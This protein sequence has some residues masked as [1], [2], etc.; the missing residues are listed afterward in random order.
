[1]AYKT[2]DI[3][4]N[5]IVQHDLQDKGDWCE[6]G[7][8]F[9][10]VF[11]RRYPH[12]ELIINPEKQSNIYAPDLSYRE[13]GLYADLKTQNTPFFLSGAKYGID[14]QYAVTFNEKDFLRYR[15]NYPGIDIYFWVDWQ[16]IRFVGTTEI[17][18]QPMVGVWRL[19]YADMLKAVASAS[20]H[21]Y[22]QRV[23]DQKGNAKGS[24][25]LDLKGGAF[26]RIA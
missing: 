25:V 11:V 5:E 12:L 20:L 3:R 17:S 24:F 2:F 23:G 10:E 19:K 9:E 8:S 14:P 1:M 13:S 6:K 4:G 26:T 22:T 21:V 15:E 16:A 7:A 18:V